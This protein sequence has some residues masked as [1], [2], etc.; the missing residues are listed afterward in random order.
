MVGSPFL[1][2]NQSCDH[3]QVDASII[4]KLTAERNL[5]EATQSYND[6]C[7]QNDQAVGTIITKI[8]WP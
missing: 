8:L 7:C 2:K 5:S 3:C 6:A 4:L 1:A